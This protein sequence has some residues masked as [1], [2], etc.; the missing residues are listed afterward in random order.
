[1]AKRIA[2][3]KPE[4][5][6]PAGCG[7][8]LCMKLCPVNRS[9]SECILKSSRSKIIIEE[10]LC[11]GCKICSNRC[12]FD[13][14][15]IINLPADFDAEP[16]HQYGKNGFRLFNLPVP[17]LGGVVGI[18]GVNGIGKSTVLKLLG[19]VFSPN[20]G[21]LDSEAD[22]K[23][24]LSFFKGTEAQLYFER[25]YSEK[26]SVSYKPQQIDSIPVHYSGTV[27]ELLLKSSEKAL[28]EAFSE[29]FDL[30]KILDRSIKDISGG[31]L[32]R[33]AIAASLMKQADMYV[34]DEP[35][36]YL[37]IKQRLKVARN[38]SSGL[39]EKN[40]MLIVEHDLIILDYLTD[41][42]HI[43]YGNPGAYGVVSQ[44][45]SSREGINSFLSGIL[46]E[47]NVRFRDYEIKFQ[48]HTPA[49]E[50]LSASAVAEWDSLVLN[51]GNFSLKTG[52]GF[53]PKGSVIGVLGENGIGK[54]TFVKMLAGL[55]KPSSG[56]IST[57]VKVSYKPQY[58]PSDSGQPVSMVLADALI[59]HKAQLITPFELDKLLDRKVN[60]LSGGELQ[61]V[62]IARCLSQDADL[63]LLDEP[64]AYLDVEQR[65]KLSKIIKSFMEEKGKTAL[66]VDHDLLFVDYISELLFVIRGEPAISGELIGP[67]GMEDGM[68]LF[69]NDLFVTFRRD[70]ESGRPRANKLDSQQDKKQKKANKLYYA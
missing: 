12:P 4:K 26:L 61:R 27:R 35:T 55:E 44:S 65:I 59:N 1:M 69:L 52:K 28:V 14:I 46:R 25:L 43:M 23:E 3:V 36:S 10:M 39:T 49:K 67:M 29:K 54:T 13:A 30:S 17:K 38:I 45:K 15:T 19:N 64:S 60:E 58:I 68:N 2:V 37:D 22:T 16:L 70:G 9:G 18:I 53:L 56:K 41:F 62:A 63:F 51:L 31:E 20:L 11:V 66:I 50:K 8:Y 33:V 5:C 47:E 24:V 21:R 6:N 32:Q 57:T 48:K 40:T 34:M 7:D 42:I